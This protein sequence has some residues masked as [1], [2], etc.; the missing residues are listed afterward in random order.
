MASEKVDGIRKERGN[1][2]AGRCDWKRV[3]KSEAAA[4]E[5]TWVGVGV[6]RHLGRTRERRH[7]EFTWKWEGRRRQSLDSSFVLW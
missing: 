1:A 7:E 5:P 2:R 4:L 6:R 3:E